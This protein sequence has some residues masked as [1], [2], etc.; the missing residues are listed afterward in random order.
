MPTSIQ[1]AS[2]AG[3]VQARSTGKSSRAARPED[4]FAQI[5]TKAKPRPNPSKEIG[6]APKSRPP[7]APARKAARAARQPREQ[8]RPPQEAAVDL[9]A[10]TPAANEL[11]GQQANLADGSISTDTPVSDTDTAED[12]AQSNEPLAG[13]LPVAAAPANVAE[14]QGAQQA[15][16]TAP[17][18]PPSSVSAEA[19]EPIAAGSATEA[20]P[21]AA[22]EPF[23]NTQV[24][25]AA[26]PSV[27][28]AGKF[29][30]Q[31]DARAEES[32][33]SAEA[34]AARAEDQP[35]TR[36]GK[37]VERP[38]PD[39]EGASEPQRPASSLQGQTDPQLSPPRHE[40]VQPN[41]QIVPAA[42]HP[43]VE[44]AVRPAAPQPVVP[45]AR[46]AEDNHSNIVTSIRTQ[47]LPGGGTMRIRL[48]PP[49]IGALQVRVEMRDGVMTA[50]FQTSND[51]A[52]R[53]LSHSLNQL[54]HT[55]ESQGVSVGRLQVEQAP[56]EHSAG[57]SPDDGQPQ[58]QPDQSMQQEQQR[59]A[60]LQRMWRKL[61]D[62][63]D[64][65]D[66]VA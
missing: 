44:V 59:R 29:Q 30:V 36:A 66:V 53:L 37:P 52:T 13:A 9:A 12:S 24:Q 39:R 35:Q 5:F 22:V 50:L 46:F 34:G 3:V 14:L 28:G 15:A 58:Q 62:G 2:A 38:K 48:D 43:A 47:L 64:P 27:D 11:A 55:L 19:Q 45:D 65:L 4:A 40:E 57:Q 54:K 56:R 33:D 51:E 41:V 16:Q 17:P 18:V 49:E 60:M 63:G 10:D 26:D 25:S 1:P 20:G 32:V 61:A 8:A 6:A 7:K 31:A 42:P 21:S 23:G